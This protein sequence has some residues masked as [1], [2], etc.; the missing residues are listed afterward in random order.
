LG[1]SP[2]AETATPPEVNYFAVYVDNESVKVNGVQ[3]SVDDFITE[4]KLQQV[5]GTN[6][7]LNVV[8]HSN[9]EKEVAELSSR[10]KTELNITRVVTVIES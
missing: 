9:Q 6:I 4:L 3:K 7:Q 10:L 8:G 5:S 1:C 2:A